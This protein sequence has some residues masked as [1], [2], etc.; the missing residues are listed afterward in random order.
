MPGLAKDAG[1]HQCTSDVNDNHLDTV[2]AIKNIRGSL[3][4]TALA[5]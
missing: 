3:I 5:A 1:V 2:D 4:L